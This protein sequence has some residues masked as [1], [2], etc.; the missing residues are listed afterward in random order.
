MA[1][2]GDR[3]GSRRVELFL[4]GEGTA[5][6]RSHAQRREQARGRAGA[7]QPFG[8]TRAGE[9]EV[10][11][12]PGQ[13]QVLEHALA[14]APV[15]VVRGTRDRASEA[16]AHA[17]VRERD[18]ALGSV[19]GKTAQEHAVGDREQRGR[20]RDAE[21]ENADGGGGERRLT[22]QLPHA[23]REIPDDRFEPRDAI[24]LVDRLSAPWT[25]LPNLRSAARRACSGVS[26]RAR[27]SSISW[28]RVRLDLAIDLVALAPPRPEPAHDTIPWPG[29]APGPPPGRAIPTG[30]ARGADASGPRA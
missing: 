3:A 18:E 11:D 17:G 30:C 16:R 12:R 15:E 1:Q 26:P 2:H 29:R 8:F 27:L 7:K 24:H 5:E 10:A 22:P 19:V 13:R 23:E 20:R 4:L 14:L 28:I 25:W 9:V 21:R 6:E